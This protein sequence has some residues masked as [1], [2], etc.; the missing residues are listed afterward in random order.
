M[1]RLPVSL[2]FLNVFAYNLPRAMNYGSGYHF[3]N[4]KVMVIG[5]LQEQDRVCRKVVQEVLEV[6]QGHWIHGTHGR[7]QHSAADLSGSGG[8]PTRNTERDRTRSRGTDHTRSN[9]TRGHSTESS[10]TRDPTGQ[11]AS[12]SSHPSWVLSRNSW[13]DTSRFLRCRYTPV[14]LLP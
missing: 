13:A 3:T 10:P 11:A 14:R 4:I 5:N 8:H 6:D 9:P 1:L 2:S 12:R 7:Q